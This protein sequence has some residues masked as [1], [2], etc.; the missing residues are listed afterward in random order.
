RWLNSINWATWWI[1]VPLVIA[2]TYSLIDTCFFG[3]IMWRCYQ[4][5]EPPPPPGDATV[6]VF[7]TT[8]NEPVE[9]VMETAQAA[10]RIRFPHRTWV[11]DDGDR[12]ELRAAA[13]A[14]G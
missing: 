10:M 12:V 7:I 2:E 11:L 8:Y 9:L 13:G 14:D 6:D 4:R 3:T 1:A 5:G